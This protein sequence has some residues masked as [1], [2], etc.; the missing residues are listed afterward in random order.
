MVRLERKEGRK[1]GRKKRSGCG[2]A[3]VRVG[4]CGHG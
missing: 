1:E 2:N 4:G 3:F